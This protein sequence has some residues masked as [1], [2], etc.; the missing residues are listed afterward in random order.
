MADMVSYGWLLGALALV[1]SILL[2]KS[3]ARLLLN[4][5]VRMD[6]SVLFL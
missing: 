6:R 4:F 5:V 2:L 3:R 1:L